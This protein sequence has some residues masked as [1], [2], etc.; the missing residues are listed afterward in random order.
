MKL[1]GFKVIDLSWYLPG[2]FLTMT[3]ADHGAE[4]IKVEP[5]NGDPSRDIGPS[6]GPTSVFFRNLNRGKKS[7]V[8]D[9]KTAAGREALLRLCDSADVVV[10]SFRPSVAARLGIGYDVVSA[11]NPGIVYCS[12]SAFGQD[13][14]YATRPAHDL[15]LEAVTGVLSLTLG[16]DNRPAIPGIPIADHLSALQGLSGVLM[17]LLRRAKTG[18]GDYLDIAMHDCLLAACVN[19]VGPALVEGRHP[20]VKHQRATGGSAFYRIYDTGDGRQL[21]LA[22]QEPKFIHTLLEVLGRLDLEPLCLRGP[23][24]HQ[25]PVI[26]F[27]NATFLQRSLPAWMTFLAR[28]DIAFA[29]VH[30][31]PEALDDPNLRARAMLLTDEFGRRH[32]A[33]AIHFGQEMAAPT[34]REPLLG[35]HT[36]EILL[37]DRA[38]FEEK[39]MANWAN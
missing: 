31:L 19:V 30:T 11:R 29:P 38:E 14:T 13:G 22:G 2:P 28:L 9:L 32:I 36:A 16:D 4:V 25:Q 23:G 21:V 18:R 3:L 24:P 5:P 33:P 15:A 37:Q 17:A 1:G 27:L 35:E 12:I 34:L 20:I 6:D 8:I 26:D 10:E 39:L 7:V